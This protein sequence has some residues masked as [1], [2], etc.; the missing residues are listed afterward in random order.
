MKILAIIALFILPVSIL[1]AD[2][3]AMYEQGIE[4]FKSANYRNA[5]LIFRK[6]VDAD[7]E[8]SERAWFYLA[9]SIYHQKRYKDAI[10]EFNRFLLSCRNNELCLESRF[11]MAESYNMIPDTFKAIEE[12]KRYIS[13]A[14]EK[15]NPLAS[16]SHERIGDIYYKQRRLDEA[17]IEWKMSIEYVPSERRT[18][19]ILKITQAL[20]GNKEY[21]SAEQMLAAILQDKD[22]LISSEALIYSG[23]INQAR[24]KH[25][26]AIKTF[27]RIPG[28]LLVQ[29]QFS[30]A[31]Y[32][33]ALSYVELGEKENAKNAL[34]NFVNISGK[35]SYYYH[36]KFQLAL[37]SELKNQNDSI[38][39]FEDIRK[40]AADKNLQIRTA[41][42]L[43]RL[44]L[45][46]GKID[47][48]IQVLEDIKKTDDESLEKAYM[49]E[50]GSAYL[51]ANR[52]DK[53]ANVFGIM[54]EKFKYEQDAD[55]IQFLQSVVDLKK[56]DSKKAAEGFEKIKEINPF[57]KYIYESQFYLATAQFDQGNFS[58]AVKYSEKYMRNGASEKRYE[59]LSLQLKSYVALE[60]YRNA[61]KVAVQL[62]KRYSDKL[63][64]ERTLFPYLEAL[65]RI[66]K[67]APAVESF[68]LKSYPDSDTSVEI[69]LA[70]GDAAY[71][72]EKWEKAEQEYSS[73]LHIRGNEEY[74]KVFYR[75]AQSKYWQ[76]DYRGVISMLTTEKFS[77]FN[78]EITANIVI[79]L[80]RSY[81]EIGES[82]K[83]YDLFMAV[84]D[85][86]YDANDFLK[87]FES[88]LRSDNILVA[89]EI[90]QN[91]KSSRD[92]YYRA[93]FAYGA[94]YRDIYSY[95]KSREYFS[96]VYTENSGSLLGDKALLE[97]ADLDWKEGKYADII[98]R[99]KNIRN[100]DFEIRK[101]SLHIRA[102]V[103]LERT[104]E[105]ITLFRR[106]STIMLKDETA[107]ILMHDLVGAL[108]ESDMIDDML[109]VGKMLAGKYPIE[110]DYVNYYTGS[111][112]FKRGMYEKANQYYG[113]IKDAKSE[114]RT[115]VMY[116]IGIIYELWYKNMRMAIYYFSQLGDVDGVYDEYTAASRLELSI[117]YNERG[118]K[119]QS[120]KLLED[121]MSR[122]DNIAIMI[123]AGDLYAQF[124]FDSDAEGIK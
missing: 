47:Q 7:D 72:A 62:M 96:Q 40:N 73:V 109:Y 93:L 54:I 59:A 35:S 91:I 56:G 14:G 74:P 36:G 94:Y 119:E 39:I 42:E 49:F 118:M 6:T 3:K 99:M 57:S 90:L 88:A 81:S 15:E 84:K 51:S 37:F 98:E 9:R 17:L 79:L 103:K 32:F 28:N 102:L 63:G 2:S 71:G 46:N 110:S 67:T 18:Q 19:L 50:L 41:I 64:I 83:A 120:K 4:A 20:I 105:A 116:K 27:S 33:M 121:L 1:A 85:H 82:D 16:L 70:K 30:D 23:R 95:K 117:L 111:F 66:E 53:A 34:Q 78:K 25:R 106:S 122:R 113:K 10:F 11:W 86:I 107:R 61:D 38:A 123:R 29:Q 104:V 45:V 87:F 97:L 68:I 5:E 76:K 58:Q 60:D 12:Y 22:P 108:A 92:Q 101:T 124:G 115:E 114:Y 89:K 100:D 75:K 43:S 21:D 69:Y 112:Y 24:G 31:Y 77:T 13:L 55:K 8:Y 65:Y 26:I 80:A 52:L 44:Y 48:A